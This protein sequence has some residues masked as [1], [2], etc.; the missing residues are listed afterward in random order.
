[1][2]GHEDLTD[3]GIEL[4][5]FKSLH[6]NSKIFFETNYGDWAKAKFSK[7]VMNKCLLM[8]RKIKQY[9]LSV[10]SL[11]SIKGKA[12]QITFFRMV[13]IQLLIRKLLITLKRIWELKTTT[14]IAKA[15]M[16][17]IQKSCWTKQMIS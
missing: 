14:S 15:L 11:T 12:L 1:M 4:T 10:E 3:K 17:T 2:I 9:Y 6:E 13:Y 5:T 8:A 16:K 7:S